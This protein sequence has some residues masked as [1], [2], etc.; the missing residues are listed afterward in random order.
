MSDDEDLQDMLDIEF[1]GGD[2]F[3]SE[4]EEQDKDAGVIPAQQAPP[5][6]DVRVTGWDEDAITRCFLQALSSYDSPDQHAEFQPK[7]N[8]IIRDDGQIQ[9]MSLGRRSAEEHV[10]V[11]PAEGQHKE[12]NMNHEDGEASTGQT[13][14]EMDVGQDVPDSSSSPF[15]KTVPLPNWALADTRSVHYK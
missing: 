9:E 6:V 1:P 7:P 12:S 10:P 3:S 4:E 5:I 8:R 14:A 13:N 2:G 11:V 15:T